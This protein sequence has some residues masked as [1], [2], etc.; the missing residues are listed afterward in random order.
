MDEFMVK[1]KLLQKSQMQLQRIASDT[2]RCAGDTDRICRALRGRISSY[3]QIGIRLRYISGQIEENEQLLRMMGEKAALIGRMYEQAERRILGNVQAGELK[4]LEQEVNNI[5]DKKEKDSL[6]EDIFQL[7]SKI[8]GELG[9]MGPGL[10]LLVSWIPGIDQE[11]DWLDMLLDAGKAISNMGE[12]Y[13]GVEGD[14]WAEWLGIIDTTGRFD[15]NWDELWWSEFKKNVDFSGTAGWQKALGIAGTIFSVGITA[16]D[17][18]DEAASGE[19]DYGRAV[20]ETVGEVLV[21]WAIGA[22][23]LTLAAAAL[24]VGAPAI[25]VGA[26]GAIV[27]WA[28][29]EIFEY[30]FDDSATEVI[31]D[32]ILNIGENAWEFAEDA[33][34]AISDWWTDLW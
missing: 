22:G 29:D 24:P 30:I 10:S 3:E 15:K 27:V 33:G 1:Y 31:S 8:V 20:A 21:D 16:K 2:N 5:Q 25:L 26:V 19:I 32:T 12:K 9:V 13:F 7:L 14:S 23:A 4:D 17:N 28:A 34:E 6:E 11:D 18:W